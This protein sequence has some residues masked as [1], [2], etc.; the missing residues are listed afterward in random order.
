MEGLADSL[1]NAA[2]AKV[3]VLFSRLRFQARDVNLPLVYQVR[4]L[5][6]SV[7][8]FLGTVFPELW[9]SAVA[10]LTF[11]A[12]GLERNGLFAHW[13]VQVVDA[14]ALLLAERDGVVEKYLRD[15]KNLV[16][17]DV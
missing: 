6:K 4:P 17:A 12:D 11:S 1:E 3:G 9:T 13:L 2:L 7:V 5:L 10:V 16:F 15:V 14:F 8:I